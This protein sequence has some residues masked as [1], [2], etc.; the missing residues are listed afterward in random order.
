MSE[1]TK[2]DEKLRPGYKAV[3]ALEAAGFM[4]VTKTDGATPTYNQYYKVCEAI[5]DATQVY[6]LV[7][8]LKQIRDM[9]P[10]KTIRSA[11]RLA[12]TCLD[13]NS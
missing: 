9:R 8:C 2:T 1:A 7:S 13:E 6:S 10:V 11:S 3:L 12:G 5:E 4:V